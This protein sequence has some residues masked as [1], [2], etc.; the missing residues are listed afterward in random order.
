MARTARSVIVAI[1]AAIALVV[2][3]PVAL[4]AVGPAVIMFHGPGVK[5][6]VFVTGADTSVFP[7]FTRLSG[8]AG[9]ET[10]NRTY[11]NVAIF[12]SMPPEATL[13][14]V[15]NGAALRVQDAWQHGRY[16]PATA[17]QPALLLTTQ[18]TKGTQPLPTDTTP[19]L[20]GGALS[21]AAIAVLKRLGIAR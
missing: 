20:W 16:Y 12:W 18:F 1:A 14:G 13:K 2:S 5:S 21:D 11:I 3:A 19:F 15:F 17:S 10:A 4:R 7:D 8:I 6:P 9:S